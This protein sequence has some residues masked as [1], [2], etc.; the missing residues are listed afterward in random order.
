MV[1]QLFHLI[2]QEM[3]CHLK[4]WTFYPILIWRTRRFY[5]VSAIVVRYYQASAAVNTKLLQWS[6]L[7]SHSRE[8][9]ITKCEGIFPFFQSQSVCNYNISLSLYLWSRNYFWIYFQ[10]QIKSFCIMIILQFH[11]T[12]CC[13]ED[14]IFCLRNV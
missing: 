4:N 7:Q 5:L 11:L 12:Y 14:N 8:P 1:F 13:N 10:G 6:W 2:F 9:V 3:L